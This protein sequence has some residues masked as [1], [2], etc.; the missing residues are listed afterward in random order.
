M[1]LQKPCLKLRFPLSMLYQQWVICVDH[2]HVRTHTHTHTSIHSHTEI[3]LMMLK[4]DWQMKSISKCL[5]RVRKQ[6][7]E[8]HYIDL[9]MKKKRENT[10]IVMSESKFQV[11]TIDNLIAFTLPR[12]TFSWEEWKKFSAI[13]FYL[14]LF[15]TCITQLRINIILLTDRD[16]PCEQLSHLESHFGLHKILNLIK[17]MTL[18]A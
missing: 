14:L 12:D 18:I 5:E 11:N 15:T 2:E 13:L 16:H 10:S 4:G 8:R 1:I 6:V 17:A 7:S 3:G 9:Q